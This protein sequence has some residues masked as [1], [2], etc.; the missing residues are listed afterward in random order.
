MLLPLIL[1]LN[2][3]RDGLLAGT[4]ARD[5]GLKGLHYVSEGLSNIAYIVARLGFGGDGESV[6]CE[7]ALCGEVWLVSFRIK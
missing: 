4:V 3:S 7:K 1:G 6:V 5:R 2:S